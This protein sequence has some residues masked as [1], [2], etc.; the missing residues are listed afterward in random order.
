MVISRPAGTGDVGYRMIARPLID[1]L[2]AVRGQVDLV[3]LRPPTLDA[4]ASALAEA[5]EARE[6]F[7][8]VHF[9]GHGALDG[10]RAAGAGAP[11]TF[12]GPGPEGVLVFEKPGGGPDEVPASR[13]A[14]VLKAAQV[15]VV[16]L[17][18]CQSGAV[19]KALEAAVATR[20]LQEGIASVVAM[21]Y[22]VYTVAAAEFMAAFYERLFVGD[23]V[24]VAVTAG[25]RRLFQA[26]L[27][28][29]PKGDMPLADWVVPVHYLRRDVSFPQA[30]T[31]RPAGDL[32][33]DAALDQ[34][35][36]PAAAQEAG[37]GS[38]D[39]VGAFVGR[40]ALF[41]ELETVARLQKVVVLRGPGGTGKTE[42][43]KAF[44]R[45][46]RDTGGVEDPRLVF[47]H[48]FEPG[49][50]SFG[51][52]GVI[53]QIGLGVFGHDF[54]ALNSD[55]RRQVVQNLLDQHRL[56]L[57]WD[58]F[59]TV[60]SMPDP[61]NATPPLDEA[62][63]RELKDF[64]GHVANG[65]R[66][67]VIITSRAREDW[68][69]S[70][71]HLA[72]GGLAAHEAAEY[73]GD[74]LA[75][76]PAAQPRRAGRPFGEL[77]EWLDGHPLS[78]RLILPHLD[79]TEPGVLLEGLQ[80]TAPL[81][82]GDDMTGG[83]TT[84]LAASIA[85][86]YTHLPAGTRRRL[87]AVSLFQGVAD[88]DV[89]TA[90]SQAPG[91]PE[92]FADA[93][94]EEWGEALDDAARV[95]LLTSLGAGMY[96]IHPALPTYVAMQWRAEE[97]DGHDAAWEAAT[98]ALL[99]AYAGLGDWL[100]QQQT[101]LATAYHQLGMIAQERGR[102]GEAEDWYTKSLAIKEDLGNRPG[103]AVTYHNLGAIVQDRGRLE[104]AEDWYTKSLAIEED[105]GNRLGMAG[106][107]HQ[108]GVV[109]Q[110]RGRLEEAED[111]YTKAL[112]IE[113]DLGN[114]P[115]MASSYHE[116]GRVAQKRG[117]LEEAEDWYTKALA[118]DADLGD[119]MAMA[120]TLAQ[121]GLLAEQ[122]GQP[123]RA[124]EQAIRSVSL[125]EQI[126]HPASGTAPAQLV[127]LTAEL[128]I[129]ALE[130][131][132]QAVTGSALPQAVRDYA[133]SSAHSGGA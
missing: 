75:P 59:E 125:F 88:A 74:L 122:Q 36:E 115:Y 17:N 86:S 98:R 71:R 70:I 5:A 10:R 34:L 80:G 108:L 41:Y 79:T 102:L 14:Q 52:D 29:S 66:S 87:A 58:N 28:P 105:L 93:S 67:V 42:L 89:L 40:D 57:I 22:T 114:R 92:R 51:L 109:A 112:A 43:A 128:G 23:T 4:L 50:A 77:M 60:A 63:Q 69:G 31:P 37:A 21:A 45:W 72:V 97:P 7:Q 48:S 19:G 95:G 20:L 6:P 9:D 103:M 33:L 12:Q 26:D 118:I 82:G 113:E 133:G 132:W 47:W 54:A 53:N 49:V 65:G 61:A 129:S 85:Y 32:S 121:T 76:Y 27:R 25:R 16:V 68:L 38:L 131:C 64:L 56:L 127:R 35:R 120:K 3:V 100:R 124:L 15:P 107:Y 55:E 44:G 8:V 119:R 101:H 96:Q 94:R 83:R 39:P 104:E 91:V 106:S 81:P 1:R 110:E 62:G 46:W 123:R 73:A 111:W 130:S 11:M 116:L 2:E 30:V 90:F 84:S 13:V 24:S 99:T 117:R 18:A 126:P 78:M